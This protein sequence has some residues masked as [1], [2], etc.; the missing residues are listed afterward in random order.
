MAYWTNIVLE[1]KHNGTLQ[2]PSK[3]KRNVNILLCVAIHYENHHNQANPDP[4]RQW[5]SK[6]I[7]SMN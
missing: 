4:Q 2:T 7:K 1:A 3:V 6:T 5:V